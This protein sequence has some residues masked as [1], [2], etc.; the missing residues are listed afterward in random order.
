MSSGES[1]LRR[2]QSQAGRTDRAESPALLSS[3]TRVDD[4][5]V[6]GGSRS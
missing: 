4:A 2:S 5:R 1:G 3:L 6:E